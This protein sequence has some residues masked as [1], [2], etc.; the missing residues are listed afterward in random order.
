MKSSLATPSEAMCIEGGPYRTRRW[1]THSPRILL[2]CLMTVLAAGCSSLHYPVNE[3]LKASREGGGYALR[4]LTAHDN[5]DGFL[6]VAA[7]SG[8]GYRAAAMAFALMEVLGETHITWD[9]QPRALLKELDAISAVSG[10][11]L[12]AAYYALDPDAFVST[13]RSRVLDF[14]LQSAFLGRVLSPAG[15]WRQTSNTYGR[16]DLLQEV[17]EENIFHGR[18][19]ADVPRRR[20]MVSI[21]AT[22]LRFGERFEFF[23]DQFDHLCSD[24]NSFPLARAVAASM[25]VPLLMSPISLWNHRANCA[26]PNNTAAVRGRAS[27]SPYVHLVDGGLADNTGVHAVLENVSANGGFVGAGRANGFRNVQK[28]VFIVVNAQVN[29]DWPADQS[30]DTPGLLRQLQSVVDVPIDRHSDTSLQLLDDTMRQWQRELRSSASTSLVAKQSFSVI[31]ISMARARDVDGGQAVRQIPTG[32][33]IQPD[34]IE[35]IRRFVRRELALNPDWQALTGASQPA[36]V[37][38]VGDVRENFLADEARQ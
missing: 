16:G 29:T 1:I 19:Y 32:L 4:N 36:R 6:L 38:H 17:L 26:V 3:P 10:G 23:Q 9:G 30:A 24:L 2:M 28:L 7:F 5:S 20:P 27:S 33:A 22:N 21:N 35:T 31:E 18:T 34:Q 11:S 15:F 8:G 37:E 25:A 12:A 13:F 14:D